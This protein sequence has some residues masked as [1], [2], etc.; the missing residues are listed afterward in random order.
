MLFRSGP[1][2]STLPRVLPFSGP[3]P[4]GLDE[5]GHFPLAALVHERHQE[6][7]ADI[8]LLRQTVEYALNSTSKE[9]TM[10]KKELEAAKGKSCLFRF[11]HL[12]LLFW[13]SLDVGFTLFQAMQLLGP[14]WR[15]DWRSPSPRR[16]TRR[17]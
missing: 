17:G 12:W 4:V 9:V 15:S 11:L 3:F 6:Q 1:R 5:A 10:L 16:R 2:D 8:S 7:T 13:L 14:A